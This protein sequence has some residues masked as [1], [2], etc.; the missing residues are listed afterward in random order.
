MEKKMKGLVLAHENAHRALTPKQSR[1]VD[2]YL[3]DLNGKQAAIRAGYSKNRAEFTGSDLVSNRKVAAVIAERMKA[4]EKRTQIAQDRVLERYWQI[5]TAN[6][7]EL[8]QYRRNNCRHCFGVG[9]EWQWTDIAEYQ[10]AVERA[11]ADAKKEDRDPVIPSD[12]GGYGFNPT[13]RPHPKCPKCFGEGHGEVFVQDTR[14]LS[15]AALALYAGVK[16]TRDGLEIKM[17]D[18]LAALEKVAR[19][20]GLFERDNTQKGA[21][22][23]EFVAWLEERTAKNGSRLPIA[24]S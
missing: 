12:A 4:R 17:H 20:V 15:P 21:G 24:D 3:I 8:V 14:D 6:A 18:Q 13:E 22:L 2:E 7:N 11:I 16:V 9:H 1:F 23:A 10:R 19:H 5:A